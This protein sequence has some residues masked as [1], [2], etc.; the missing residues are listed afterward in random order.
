ML[1]YVWDREEQIEA[2]A[3]LVNGILEQHANEAKKHPLAAIRKTVDA[4]ELARQIADIEKT[5]GPS[6]TLSQI[7]RSKDRL[8]SLSDQIAWIRD[9]K[10]RQ[11]L[12]EQIRKC[13]QKYRDEPF[14][15][16]L[17][18]EGEQLPYAAGRNLLCVC[19][20][21]KR[22]CVAAGVACASSRA[23]VPPR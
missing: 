13:W 7:A 19:A 22:H 1:R 3:A 5:V 23:C 8:A 21:A 2:L 17:R 15:P 6:L 16:P 18:G 12:S 11:H 14:S 10:I 20:D 9:E 4:E